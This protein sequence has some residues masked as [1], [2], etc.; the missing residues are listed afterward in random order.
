MIF[1]DYVPAKECKN[2]EQTYGCICVKCGKC[3]RVFDNGI[4]VDE[5]VTTIDDDFGETE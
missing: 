2:Q 4:M 5:G 3:G 1:I